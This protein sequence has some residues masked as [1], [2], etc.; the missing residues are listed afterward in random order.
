MPEMKK[1]KKEKTPLSD[2]TYT[3]TFHKNIYEQL[4]ANK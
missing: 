1:K 2:P 4:F 3:I